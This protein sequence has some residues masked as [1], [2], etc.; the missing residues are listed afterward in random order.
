[1]T[2]QNKNIEFEMRKFYA[3]RHDYKIQKDRS[4][5]WKQQAQF[6]AEGKEEEARL[7]NMGLKELT[8]K[9]LKVEAQNL[10]DLDNLFYAKNPFISQNCF[11]FVQ[12]LEST[13]CEN[14]CCKIKLEFIKK[15]QESV[16]TCGGL[17]WIY[18]VPAA[19]EALQWKMKDF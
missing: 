18:W 11:N 17:Q 9:E 12:I 16:E 10:T 14:P 3:Q 1:M 8:E 19:V 4:E 5:R 6:I 2:Q 13:T 15:L 7:M